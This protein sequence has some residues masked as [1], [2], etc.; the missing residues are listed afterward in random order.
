MVTMFDDSLLQTIGNLQKFIEGVLPLTFRPLLREERSRW[1]RSTL[2][3]F[4]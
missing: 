1:I 2:V 4:K 3:R